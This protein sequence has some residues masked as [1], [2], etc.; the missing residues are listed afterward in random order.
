MHVER[1]SPEMPGDVQARREWQIELLIRRLPKRLQSPVR[2]LRQPGARWVRIPVGLLLIVGGVFS[3]LPILGLWMLPLGLVL[4][5]EDVKPLRSLTDR[6]LAWIER[7][8]PQWMGLSPNSA[9]AV[10]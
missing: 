8:R 7:R 10:Q 1:L 6:A 9:S 5:A 2:W 3:I 4:L